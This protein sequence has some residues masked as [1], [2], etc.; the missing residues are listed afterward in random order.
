[1]IMPT[2]IITYRNA[3]AAA[4]VAQE[5]PPQWDAWMLAPQHPYYPPGY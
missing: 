2:D 3:Q 1:M 5:D 4:E